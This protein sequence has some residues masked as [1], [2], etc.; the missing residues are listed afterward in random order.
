ML[1]TK[2]INKGLVFLTAFALLIG[3]SATTLSYFRLGMTER[4]NWGNYSYSLKESGQRLT[5]AMNQQRFLKKFLE[6]PINPSQINSE[7]AQT[8]LDKET[9]LGNQVEDVV[10]RYALPLAETDDEQKIKDL[11][12]KRD[13]EIQKLIDQGSGSID[14]ARKKLASDQ[15]EIL[16]KEYDYLKEDLKTDIRFQKNNFW[17]YM[18]DSQGNILTNISGTPNNEAEVLK[19]MNTNGQESE[20]I[21][22]TV[23]APLKKIQERLDL[24]VEHGFED[25]QKVDLYA[26][27]LP[28]QKFSGYIALKNNSVIVRN[29]EVA[30][31]Y[32]ELGRRIFGWGLV[33]FLIGIVLLVVFIRQP[34]VYPRA[35]RLLLKIPIDLRLLLLVVIGFFALISPVSVEINQYQVALH[36]W[37][38]SG[39]IMGIGYV[40]SVIA[41]ILLKNL[42]WSMKGR[43]EI[44]PFKMQKEKSLLF[45]VFNWYTS[46][47]LKRQRI[48]LS[49]IVLFLLIAG[50]GGAYLL[51]F[52]IPIICILNYWYLSR[53]SIQLLDKTNQVLL[54]NHFES[55][56]AD[57]FVEAQQNTK[58]MNRIIRQS[59]QITNRSESLKT[60]LLTNV[61]HDLRTPLTSIVSYGDLLTNEELSE[62]ERKE[63][64]TII[65]QKA[66]RM[67]SLIE[68]LFEVTKMN[69]GDIPL[70]LAEVD[71]GQLIQQAV[72]EY[73]EEFE[74]RQLKVCYEKPQDPLTLQLDGE[75]MWRVF[76]NLM[77]NV[78]KYAMPG[79]RVYL[80]LKKKEEKVIIQLKNISEHELNEDGATLVERFKRGDESRHTEGSG[81]GLAIVNSILSLHDGTLDIQV[82]GDLFKITITLLIKKTDDK[83]DDENG[84]S[85][86]LRI[87]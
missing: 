12:K 35:Q 61:G 6:S 38:F 46:Q 31:L 2:W 28:K 81:L 68:S 82:D 40:L 49:G 85:G 84:D 5:S 63:Y 44:P 11:T 65:N 10:S 48:W 60:E 17:I 87:M 78:V 29:R 52:F 8:F 74:K 13:E 27:H 9:K 26:E 1:A 73:S 83:E 37:K 25:A 59:E 41:V 15:N 77:S 53:Q 80:K 58:E 21:S 23:E 7:S 22:V 34:I 18:K 14:E 43:G 24:K 57:N 39:F 66:Q 19:F 51:W 62:T 30:K 47:S 32:S 75:K 56:G 42:W 50:F 55:Y 54:E 72:A 20:K 67:K 69:H 70:D 79:T 76:D 3:W 45:R 64:I 33:F 4:T 36:S 86:E 71:L 16:Q